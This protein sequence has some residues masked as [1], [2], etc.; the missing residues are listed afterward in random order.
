MINSFA[1][2]IGHSGYEFF[3]K[4]FTSKMEYFFIDSVHHNVHH[5]YGYLNYGVYFPFWDNLMNTFHH[6]YK[7]DREDFYKEKDAS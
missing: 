2:I 1:N 4:K 7:E 5:K 3:S 6:K